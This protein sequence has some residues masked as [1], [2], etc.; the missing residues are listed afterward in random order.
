[1]AA[2]DFPNS[3]TVGQLYIANGLTYEWNGVFWEAKGSLL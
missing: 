2:L 1:M 3:P